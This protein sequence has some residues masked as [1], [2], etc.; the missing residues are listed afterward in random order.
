MFEHEHFYIYEP[1]IEIESTQIKKV[2]YILLYQTNDFLMGLITN[3]DT[4][5]TLSNEFLYTPN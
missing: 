2:Q 3:I 4:L 1:T 5:H